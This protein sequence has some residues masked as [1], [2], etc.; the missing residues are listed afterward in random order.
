MNT[1]P[2]YIRIR[3]WYKWIIEYIWISIFIIDINI[4]QKCWYIEIS[5]R[6]RSQMVNGLMLKLGLH[7]K[8]P[9]TITSDC[10]VL[11]RFFKSFFRSMSIAS[12]FQPWFENVTWWPYLVREEGG[13]WSFGWNMFGRNQNPAAQAVAPE[14]SAPVARSPRARRPTRQRNTTNSTV[15]RERYD[16]RWL[17]TLM[18]ATVWRRNL[19]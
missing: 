5:N 10:R 2:E 13:Y 12:F 6:A 16:E 9:Y 7:G 1:L 11:C 3:K 18:K 19:F 17:L 14:P 4:C 8:C 15:Y